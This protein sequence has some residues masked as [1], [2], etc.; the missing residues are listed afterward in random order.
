MHRAIVNVERQRCYWLGGEMT[1]G[2]GRRV[3]SV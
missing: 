2:S 3:A 1:K